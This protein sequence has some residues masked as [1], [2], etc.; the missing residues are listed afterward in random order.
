MK[1][2]LLLFY[3]TE[4]ATEDSEAKSTSA[5]V[6][7]DSSKSSA[8]AA[9]EEADVWEM[10]SGNNELTKYK[11]PEHDNG[12]KLKASKAP[13]AD[14][15]VNE[16]EFSVVRKARTKNGTRTASRATSN[17]SNNNN[18]N[19]SSGHVSIAGSTRFTI[20]SDLDDEEYYDGY[21]RRRTSVGDKDRSKESPARVSKRINPKKS[22]SSGSAPLDKRKQKKRNL[23]ANWYTWLRLVLI[24]CFFVLVYFLSVHYV[25]WRR[26]PI[27][28]L[29]ENKKET[30]K[31]TNKV[32]SAYILLFL[33]ND[34]D[35]WI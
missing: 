1:K 10:A 21:T 22:S 34:T 5:S 3:R 33:Y 20:L 13:T 6:N 15:R 7:E 25:Q 4:G 2:C 27:L 17:N 26:D 9:T 16:E 32:N 30:N 12:N 18:N 31:Q 14:R 23:T 29:W 24:V 19:N 28:S 35:Q 11:S 8:N